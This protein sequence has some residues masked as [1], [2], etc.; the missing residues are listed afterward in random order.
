MT[1]MPD[2]VKRI[3]TIFLLFVLLATIALFN[4]TCASISEHKLITDDAKTHDHFG[5]S[6]AISGS[7]VVIG[8]RSDVKVDNPG[9]AYVF[10]YNGNGWTQQA[11][12]ITNDG[13]AYN[14]FGC[15]VAISGDT[16]VVGNDYD[17]VNGFATG[18][19]YVFVRNGNSWTQQAKLTAKDG[20]GNDKFGCSV[21]ISGDT[22]VIGALDDVT[23]GETG[24]AYV[25]VRSGS[26]WNQQA[27]LTAK[28][29]ENWDYFG[30][31]IAISGDT[32]V[33]GA[34]GDDDKRDESGSAYVFVRSGSRWTQQAK[35]TADDGQGNDEFGWSVAISFDTAVV[36]VNG[37]N[38]NG[39][40]SG[41]ARVFVR[42]VSSNWTQQAK[43]IADDGEAN[44]HFGGSV[45]ISGDTAVI[46][47]SCDDDNGEN[48]GS[49]YAFVRN[50]SDNWNQQSKLI[51]ANG[52][53][54]VFFGCSVAING[55]TAVVGSD[56][57][58][59]N[60]FETGSA[61]VYELNF[62]ENK[63]LIIC[64]TIVAV[65]ILVI[66]IWWLIR[67]RREPATTL[68]LKED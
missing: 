15:S 62:T 11:K 35:L 13:Q 33:V 38:D 34:W 14:D 43:L 7:T 12:L 27:K 67:K 18:S 48:S 56:R 65:I 46:G 3:I 21:A 9:S 52:E 26:R 4:L 51:A 6:V 41:S 49:A 5:C 68:R 23:F 28:D 59:D 20:E 58:N 60:G 39:Y 54:G 53:A 37:D 10:V 22:V 40:R 36:G 66:I 17:D 57:D 25:F 1:I 31:S 19:A 24:S 50:D 8:A 42:S 64:L 44:D 30:C 45:A 2:I 63:L 32:T 47:S 55:D 29:G 61:Y 16:A